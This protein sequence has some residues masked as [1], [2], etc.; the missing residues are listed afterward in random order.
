MS[1]PNFFK[2]P[3]SRNLINQKECLTQV[4][5]HWNTALKKTKHVIV[6]MDSNIDT[7]NS[8]YNKSWNVENLKKNYLTF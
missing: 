4:L 5:N 2:N 6:M 1:T 7:L 8:G 3:Q